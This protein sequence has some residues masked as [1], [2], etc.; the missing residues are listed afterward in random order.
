MQQQ[1]GLR[2]GKYRFKHAPGA[3]GPNQGGI[4]LTGKHIPA[5]L[6]RALEWSAKHHG[7]PVTETSIRAPNR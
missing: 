3:P 2:S 5:T 6:Q 4:S 7:I 1:A